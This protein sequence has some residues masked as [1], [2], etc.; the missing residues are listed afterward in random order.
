V[1]FGFLLRAGMPA[2]FGLILVGID[3]RGAG[4]AA[5]LGWTALAALGALG[6]AGALLLGVLAIV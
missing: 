2:A 4:G 3:R 5:T 1:A 6:C